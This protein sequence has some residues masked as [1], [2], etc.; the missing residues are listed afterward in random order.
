MSSLRLLN[1][2]A[3]LVA[4]MV[5]LI[6]PRL[7]PYH[8]ADQESI[9]ARNAAV[10]SSFRSVPY[11]IGE[12]VV[13]ESEPEVPAA[14]VEILQPNVIFSRRYV[15][16]NDRRWLSVLIVHCSD[17]RD[18]QGHFPPNCYPANGWT[19]ESQQEYAIPVR[20][21]QMALQAYEFRRMRGWAQEER[22]RVLN[23]FVLPNGETALAM[24]AV[25]ELA[26][27]YSTSIQGVAQVQIIA[28]QDMSIEASLEATAE[29]LEG[30]LP[31]LQVLEQGGL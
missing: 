16:T 22:L 2:A 31:H 20:S 8:R 15:N 1:K 19:L 10:L 30:L 7:L 24:S 6:L 12:W 17:A 14:A 3:P 11:R 25:R 23:Y 26:R 4:V 9:L 18:M 27:R 28:S 29:L 5:M 21:R 13:G